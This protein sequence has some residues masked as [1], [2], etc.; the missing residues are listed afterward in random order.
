MRCFA[1]WN[2]STWSF[3]ISTIST[4]SYHSIVDSAQPQS[5]FLND[6]YMPHSNHRILIVRQAIGA[7]FFSS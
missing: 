4:V 6:T 2:E 5:C 7:F 1:V 3:V